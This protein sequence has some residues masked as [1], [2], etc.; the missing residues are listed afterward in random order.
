MCLRVFKEQV[1]EGLEVTEWT[2]SSSLVHTPRLTS[3][4]SR[5]LCVYAVLETR[6]RFMY[7]P[8]ATSAMQTC[9]IYSSE[10]RKRRKGHHHPT[11]ADWIPSVNYHHPHRRLM[12]KWNVD[13]ERCVGGGSGVG[14][15]IRLDAPLIN[16]ASQ[17]LPC[18]CSS[19]IYKSSA[20]HIRCTFRTCSAFVSADTLCGRPD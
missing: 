19:H 7:L 11:M 17:L 13:T 5:H 8:K 15:R 10:E 3:L 6:T 4:G 18:C 9:Q 12:T 1:A 14:W 20:L 16:H 2:G